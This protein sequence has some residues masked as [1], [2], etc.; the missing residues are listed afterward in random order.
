MPAGKPILVTGSHRSGSTWLGKMIASAPEVVYLQEPF[1]AHYYDPGVCTYYFEEPFRYITTDNEA[2]YYPHLQRTV[3]L[4]YNVVSKLRLNHD[5]Y[6]LHSLARNLW[7]FS[8]GRLNGR[9]PLFK[10]PFAIF[11]SSW[12]A[13]TFDM[14]VVISIRHPAAFVSSVKRF[15]WESPVWRLLRQDL[16]MRDYLHPLENEMRNFIDKPRSI[17][18]QAAYFWKLIYYVVAQFRQEFP[19]WCYVRHED[20]STEPRKGFE[21]VFDYLSLPFTAR[22]RD[23]IKEFTH[24]ENVEEAPGRQTVYHLN[25][26]ANIHNWK[27]RLTSAEI[28]Q[29]RLLTAAVWP[30]FYA[31]DDW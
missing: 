20:L 25:S 2:I 1:N 10:D 9:R 18:E 26:A 29:I 24:A 6:A 19:E 14:D 8:W 16:L 12:L 28:S 30:Q 22:S 23:T 3:A 21:R 13:N 31:E 4:K 5:R 17:V 7:L 27:H 15:Q 11:S